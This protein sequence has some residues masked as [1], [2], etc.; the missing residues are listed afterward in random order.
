VDWQTDRR[1]QARMLVAV[2]LVTLLPIGFVY[3][4]VGLLNTVGLPM[5]RWVTGDPWAGRFYVELWLVVV[6][7]LVGFVAQLLLGDD[8]ALR[9][10]GARRVSADERPELV[11]RVD[12]LA[13]T[14]VLPAP[15]VAVATSEVP[16][17]FA[18]GRRSSSATVVVTT[19]LLDTLSDEELDAV[20]AHEL[21]HIKNRDMAVMSLAYFLPSLTYVIAVFAFGLLRSIPGAF[22]GFHHSDGDGAKGL[23]MAVVVLVVSTVLTLAVSALFWAAS[24]V[25]FRV[26]SRYREYAADRGAAAITG[27][28]SAL[29]SALRTI[30]D[31]MKEA[32][33]RDL[34]E[35]DGGLEALYLV[36]IDD[37]QFGEDRTLIASDVFPS[38]HPSTTDRVEHLR[39]LESGDQQ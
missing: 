6:G 26:L 8:V 27:N 3:T 32:P 37:S 7:I 9:A 22:R 11:G 36:P 4:M 18:I 2:V 15:T 33:D 19:A 14:A 23:V 24:F 35:Q 30:D 16:N 39:E 13:R 20:L 1:L 17:A 29:A 12:R 10:V 31:E 38:T 21:A 34:R 25:L 28:P 5:A